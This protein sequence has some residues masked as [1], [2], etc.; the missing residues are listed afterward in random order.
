[1]MPK[2]KPYAHA[3]RVETLNA[4]NERILTWE[5]LGTVYA[6]VSTASGNQQ[7][8]NDMLRIQATHTATTYSADVEPGDRLGDYTVEYVI[9]GG[10]RRMAQLFLSQTAERTATRK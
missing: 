7:H 4:W 6:A 1:M 10:G 9:P 3:R 5:Q 8:L 2:V